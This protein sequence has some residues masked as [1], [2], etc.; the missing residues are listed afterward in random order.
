MKRIHSRVLICLSVCALA[1]AGIEAGT[2]RLYSAGEVPNPR[3]V[4]RILGHAPASARPATRGLSLVSDE[5]QKQEQVPETLQAAD[6]GRDV[7]DLEPQGADAVANTL[8][9]D[10]Q[11]QLKQSLAQD[12]Q[13]AEPAPAPAKETAAAEAPPEQPTS[14]ALMVNFANNSAR[15]STEQMPALDAV[16][17]GIKLAGYSSKIVIEGHANATGK[18]EH[19]LKLS[20]RRAESVKHYLV[21][22][23]AIPPQLLIAVGLGEKEPLNAQDPS[24]SENRRVQFTPMQG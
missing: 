21:T 3:V 2:V 16:A 19:N 13:P 5:P 1:S 8:P 10:L 11:E 17:Q 22:K 9:P 6:A 15:V 12:Q 20:Q 18:T 23:H 14:L 4:A 7:R 24:A